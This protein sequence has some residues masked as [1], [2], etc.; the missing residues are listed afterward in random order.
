MSIR[1]D[2]VEN[3]SDKFFLSHEPLEDLRDDDAFGHAHYSHALLEILERTHSRDSYAIGLFGALGVGK[4]SIINE[5]KRLLSEEPGRTLR[6]SYD[7]ITLDAWRYSDE[8]F[9]REFLLD[10]AEAFSCRKRIRDRIAK[11]VSVSKLDYRRPSWT[12]ALRWAGVFAVIVVST[13][14]VGRYL[15]ASETQFAITLA[16]VF[17]ALLAAIAGTLAEL[18]KPVTIVEETS[19]PVHPDEFG[20]IFKEVLK[21]T[22]VR[23]EDHRLVVAIDNLDRAAG[24]VV[25]RVLGAVKSFLNQ[26]ACIYILPCD[27]QGLIQHVQESRGRPDASKPLSLS[28]ATEYLRKFF[29]VTLTVRELLTE[30]L[31]AYIDRMLTRLPFLS[32]RGEIEKHDPAKPMTASVSQT[33]RD[34]VGLV[35]RVAVLNNPRQVLHLANRLAASY[36]LAEERGK[37]GKRIRENVLENLGFLAKLVVIEERWPA[38]YGLVLRYPDTLR[39]LRRYFATEDKELLPY[40]LGATLSSDSSNSPDIIL[41]WESGLESFLRRTSQIHSDYVSDFLLLRERTAVSRI[42]NYY[43][44]RDASLSGDTR[45]VVELVVDESTDATEAVEELLRELRTRYDSLDI[46]SCLSLIS[47]LVGIAVESRVVL[48]VAVRSRIAERVAATLARKNLSTELPEADLPATLDLLETRAGDPNTATFVQQ[49]VASTDMEQRFEEGRACIG[50]LVRHPTILSVQAQRAIASQLGPLVADSDRSVAVREIAALARESWEDLPCG[51][52][53]RALWEKSIEM[54]GSPGAEAD[55][56]IAF[57]DPFVSCF[58]QELLE[59]LCRASASKLGQPGPSPETELALRIIRIVPPDLIP[60]TSRDPLVRGLAASYPTAADQKER[61]KFLQAFF[62][63]LPSLDEGQQAAFFPRFQDFITKANIEGLLSAMLDVGDRRNELTDL[64][65]V[66]D[67]IRARAE[68]FVADESVRS[69]FFKLI[70]ATQHLE[71]L[72]ELTQNLWIKPDVTWDNESEVAA[73]LMNRAAEELRREDFRT[74]VADL[75]D[76]SAEMPA[77]KRVDALALLGSYPDNYTKDFLRQLVDKLLNV[78]LSSSSLEDRKAGAALWRGI[79]EKASDERDRLY[80]RV[81]EFVRQEANQSTIASKP[82]RILVDLLV[83]ERDFMNSSRRGEFVDVVL[84]LVEEGKPDEV[85]AY[86]HG[87][88]RALYTW[89]EAGKRVPQKVL[90][91]LESQHDDQNT[92]NNLQTLEA[93]LPQIRGKQLGR[94]NDFLQKHG[95]SAPVRE[96]QERQSNEKRSTGG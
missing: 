5:L 34:A 56:T 9:R 8:N 38:F 50:E 51:L 86:G 40:P 66:L 85:R 68:V 14:L 36:L 43:M 73:A 78:W 83:G 89:D 25:M 64:E 13:G 23:C 49:L 90:A 60:S 27:E 18:F 28:E 45:R 44:F 2:H 57:V 11:N 70:D 39:N 41:D 7:L 21:E 58:D 63:A 48:S 4:T 82:G 16:G 93:Y 91:L 87:M 10:L 54:L 46:P 12:T 35:F 47:C 19:P 62:H 75:F 1:R 94:L 72:A 84:R 95:E 77:E 79:G 17:S 33:N 53:P 81:L 31:E 26:A 74:L 61:G 30:D 52:L 29:Q 37:T 88:L 55:D 20:E 22:Q 71:Q 65:G 24:D 42:S 67:S 69:G 80:E 96:H 15:A 32:D 6:H 92:R 3:Q 76:L 59:S